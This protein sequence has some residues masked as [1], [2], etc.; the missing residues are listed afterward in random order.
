[1]IVYGSR[2]LSVDVAAFLHKCAQRLDRLSSHSPH[3]DIV[4]LFVDVGEIESAV[5][6]A[7]QADCDD[8][9]P[10]LA[11]WSALGRAT[12][13]AFCASA[14]RE[15]ERLDAALAAARIAAAR[16]VDT[17][18]LASV[19]T[20]TAE[21]FAYYGLYPEQY[22][23]AAR[24]LVDERAPARLACIG[25]R[26]IG[27]PLAHLVAAAA[28]ARGVAAESR[29][30]RPRGHPFDRT[31]AIGAGL[32]R[33]IEQQSHSIVA[34]VDEGPGLSGSSFAA[35]VDAL[36][37]YGVPDERIFLLASWHAPDSA[38]RS[39]RGQRA[40]RTH[41]KIIAGFDAPLTGENV[42]DW[43][44]GNW[45]QG[46]F[47]DRRDAWPAV[48]PQHERRKYVK[49]TDAAVLRFAGLGRYGREK[50]DRAERLADAGFGAEPIG[51]RNGFLE[52]RLI[53]G[54]PLDPRSIG[55]DALDRAADYIAFL[56]RTFGT[57][58]PDDLEEL[59]CMVAVNLRETETNGRPAKAGRYVH[60]FSFLPRERVAVDGRMLPHEWIQTSRGIVKTDGLDHHA[61]DFFPASRDIA[62][63]VA[64]TIVE[65]GLDDGA[66]T[67]FVQQYRGRSGDRG[68]HQRL[69]FYHI[70][71]LAFRLGYTT[72]AAETLAGTDD[73]RAFIALRERY[74][75]LLTSRAEDRW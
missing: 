51:L 73:G 7:L 39:P 36:R 11:G 34:V 56:G 67:Y 54:R 23:A 19:T 45:R 61:D 25:I 63:D 71:Y 28:A 6:D 26:S 41:T 37:E 10:E 48:Q 3:D 35:A 22:I 14:D 75:H 1:V 52:E 57:G 2:T 42:E 29:S 27:V 66:A 46:T 62:W 58:V 38:L 30:V 15:G 5:A 68:I 65:L 18:H 47:G 24:R 13:D 40:W 4:E 49:R 44:A 74:R 31:L 17:N 60:Q 53:A 69:P 72:L 50:L 8:E 43:S 59:A 12:A 64:G 16:L 21:G 32:K 55:R 9:L 70:A 20:K 33:W